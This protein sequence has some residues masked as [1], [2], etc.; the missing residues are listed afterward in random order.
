MM[1][2]CCVP[3]VSLVMDVVTLVNNAGD[4]FGF[5]FA[6]GHF[7]LLCILKSDE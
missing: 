4:V 1:A 5:S 2:I 7:Y 3:T 6:G